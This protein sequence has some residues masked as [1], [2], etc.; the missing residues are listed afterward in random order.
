M[1]ML[2]K[3]KTEGGTWNCRNCWYHVMGALGYDPNTDQYIDLCVV[4]DIPVD[5]DGGY[6]C[7][8]FIHRSESMIPQRMK[9]YHFL[10]ELKEM[11]KDGMDLVCL[12]DVKKTE[13]KKY[14]AT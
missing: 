2:T 7:A 12:D 14:G 1:G 3:T 6:L 5:R 9:T 8:E 4:K 10:E 13:R 11:K